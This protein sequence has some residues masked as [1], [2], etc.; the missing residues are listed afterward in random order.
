[1]SKIYDALRKAAGGEDLP[2]EP[3]PVPATDAGRAPHGRPEPEAHAVPEPAAPLPQPADRFPQPDAESG[4]RD[5]EFARELGTLRAN[6][7]RIF[8]DQRPRVIL[9]AGSVPGEGASTVAAMFCQLLAEDPRLRV[10]LVDADFRNAGDRAV[11]PVETGTGLAS[12]LLG[13]ARIEDVIRGTTRGALDVIPSEGVT[14]D[15]YPVCAEERVHPV[16]SRLRAGYHVT[17]LDAAPILSAPETA[18]LA[19]MVDGVV[20]VVRSGRTKR[21]VVQRS[22]DQLQKYGARVLG[23]V[24]NRQQY[25]IPE[26]IYRRL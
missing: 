5:L 24:M 12:L 7:D 18:V 11:P 25:V 3:E 14:L 13:R 8:G 23:A 6:L 15:P 17:V 16:L 26:F 21:E 9:L 2:R 20:L 1:M 19:G 4:V 22:L 10:A